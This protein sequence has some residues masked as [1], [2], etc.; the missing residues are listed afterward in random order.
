MT[1]EDGPPVQPQ[2]PEAP[3]HTTGIDHVTIVGSNVADT[4]EFYRDVLGMPLVMRQPN[5]DAPTVTHLFFDAGNGQI[6]TFFV[7]KGR[8]TEGQPR[9]TPLGGV[10]HLS[11]RIE[12]A[13]FMTA[14]TG[15]TD[16]GYQYNEFD[17]GVFHSLY[18]RDHN[19]M[20]VEL[21]TDAYDIPDDRRAEVL[22][23]AHQER[24]EA[25]ATHAEA[26]HLEAALDA[27]GLDAEPVDLDD[28]PAGAG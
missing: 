11:F 22:A 19:G 15:L 27:L 1:D 2:L 18:T 26:T 23:R 9:R 13:A 7:E 14:K 12:P 20:M 28:A 17:R 4:I 6:L 8:A 3:I 24:V 16:N 10:H 25:G 21:S 5:L